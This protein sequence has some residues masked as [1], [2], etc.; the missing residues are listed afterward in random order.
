MGKW[1]RPEVIFGGATIISMT[2]PGSGETPAP[3]AGSAVILLDTGAN[4]I[5]SSSIRERVRDG[6]S[7]RYL[8]PEPVER[9]ISDRGLYLDI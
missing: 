7:I 2:R 6:R 3:P 5:S 8:V 9:Y 1:R 4:T